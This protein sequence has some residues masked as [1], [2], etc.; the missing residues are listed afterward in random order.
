MLFMLSSGRLSV[1][2]FGIPLSNNIVFNN[3]CIFLISKKKLFLAT[4]SHE[5]K[6]INLQTWLLECE[7][8]VI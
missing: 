1:I 3:V 5:S 2:S 8:L 7:S 4:S 6:F